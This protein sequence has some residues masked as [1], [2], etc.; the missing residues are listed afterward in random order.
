[1]IRATARP[2][3]PT[4]RPWS[5]PVTPEAAGSSPVAAVRRWAAAPAVGSSV[6]SCSDR[7]VILRRLLSTSQVAL[8]PP[9]CDGN[10]MD[11]RPRAE[12]TS[13]HGEWSAGLSRILRHIRVRT[14]LI[15]LVVVVAIGSGAA[16]A[17]RRT[18][19]RSI[20]TGVV[21]IDTSLAYQGGSAAGTGI[22][23]TSSGEI[24]T[25]NHVIAGATTIRVLVPDGRGY[26]PGRDSRRRR[27]RRAGR[28]CWARSRR[29]DHIG[30]GEADER[31]QRHRARHPRAAAGHESRD[32]LHRHKRT[33]P[34]RDHHAREWAAAVK[35][36]QG[37]RKD[38]PDVLTKTH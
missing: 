29:R 23:L 14:A 34:K 38:P 24:L 30:R 13:S 15:A 17:A 10:V 5:W 32:H 16:Y 20:G 27:L 2:S 25:N 36:R 1:M 9:C 33:E 6:S 11:D 12:E 26:G 18:T 37:R 8:N 19:T 21:V 35:P 22:V 31:C 28:S 4:W 7:L 3:S